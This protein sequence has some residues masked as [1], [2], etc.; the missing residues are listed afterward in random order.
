MTSSKLTEAKIEEITS[1]LQDKFLLFDVDG[2]QVIN[3]KELGAVMRSFGE[4]PTEEDLNALMKELDTDG[5][6]VLEFKEFLQLMEKTDRL[7]VMLKRKLTEKQQDEIKQKFMEFDDDHDGAIDMRELR[8][9]I[10]SFGQTPTD[11]ELQ[12]LLDEL[13][14]DKTN[15]LEFPEFLILMQQHSK[16]INTMLNKRYLVKNTFEIEF[17]FQ[18]YILLFVFVLPIL[19]YLKKYFFNFINY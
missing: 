13:D 18:M 14:A 4:N 3:R 2:D 7:D 15:L 9:V 17:M 12:A 19:Q 11:E 1:E 5:S 16:Y 8:N 10:Q 6:D